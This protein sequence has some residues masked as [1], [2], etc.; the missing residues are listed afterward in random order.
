M[1]KESNDR[2]R[3]EKEIWWTNERERE[4]SRLLISI[5]RVP[6]RCNL[7]AWAPG[8]LK[9]NN[10]QRSQRLGTSLGHLGAQS[11]L[12]FSL[13]NTSQISSYTYLHVNVLIYF[14]PHL[15]YMLKSNS[16]GKKKNPTF[17]F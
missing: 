10:H 11:P 7:A 8:H 16:L 12:F 3:R 13:P 17:G 6:R 1:G 9:L 2:K 15:F 14:T 4:R 5:Q